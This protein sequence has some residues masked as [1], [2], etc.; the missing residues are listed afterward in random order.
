MI[1]IALVL[2]SKKKLAS[3]AGLLKTR[4]PI[5][6]MITN[7]FI[8][9]PS[10]DNELVRSLQNFFA[11]MNIEDIFNVQNI[12]SWLKWIIILKQINIPS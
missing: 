3:N 10:N 8:S 6:K 4:F 7:N 1:S 11:V 5:K 12:N 9:N 2:D